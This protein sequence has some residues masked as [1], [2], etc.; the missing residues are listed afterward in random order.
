LI[1]YILDKIKRKKSVKKPKRN[2]SQEEPVAGGKVR[3]II[4]TLSKQRK[5]K[6]RPEARERSKQLENVR[7]SKRGTVQGLRSQFEQP[8]LDI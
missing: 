4:K 8:R 2:N 1:K 5:S 7:R 6:Q 3:E